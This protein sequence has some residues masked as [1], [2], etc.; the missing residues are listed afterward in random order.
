MLDIAKSPE[1]SSELARLRRQARKR[2]FRIPI[3]WTG[4]FTPFDTR[5]EPPFA[6]TGPAHVPVAEIAAA[7]LAHLPP[8]KPKRTCQPVPVSMGPSP[9]VAGPLAINGGAS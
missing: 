9:N 2:N 6:S 1:K 7:V 8:P 3:N 4:N 5:I